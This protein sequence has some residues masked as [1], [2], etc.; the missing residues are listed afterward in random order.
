MVN[1]P[2]A[3][4]SK[5]FRNNMLLL[6][7]IKKNLKGKWQYLFLFGILFSVDAY[8]QQKLSIVNGLIKNAEYRYAFIY[9]SSRNRLY[10]SGIAEGR[11]QF[12]IN[13]EKDFELGI[14]YLANDSTKTYETITKNSFEP[15]K[16]KK[17]K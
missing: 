9:V 3:L 8:A 12:A 10:K 14:L 1:N 11:F 2:S 7:L 16:V 17:L 13:K 6:K 5:N 15:F 4:S